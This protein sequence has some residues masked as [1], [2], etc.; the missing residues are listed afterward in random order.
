MAILSKSCIFAFAIAT[1]AWAPGAI[2]QPS[3]LPAA[4]AAA[5][6]SA[7]SAASALGFRTSL[8]ASPVGVLGF[9]FRTVGGYAI[10]VVHRLGDHHGVHF[11]ITGIHL[12]GKEIYT[13]LWT[14]GATIGYR[15]HQR[16][17]GDTAFAGVHGGYK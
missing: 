1:L 2:A 17:T 15:W 12:H 11:E 3:V 7:A 6:T 10:N 9:T 14:F 4:D 5:S 16:P 13:H 8:N